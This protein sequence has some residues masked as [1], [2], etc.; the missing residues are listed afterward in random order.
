MPPTSV[1]RHPSL[2]NKKLE[3][4][5][6]QRQKARARLDNKRQK[7]SGHQLFIPPRHDESDETYQSTAPAP[8][9]DNAELFPTSFNMSLAAAE[10]TMH[11]AIR[12]ADLRDWKITLVIVD[13][14]GTPVLVKRLDGAP[15]ASYDIALGRAKNAANF[16]KSTGEIEQ[17][18]QGLDRALKDTE[19]SPFISK[20][21]GC[22]MIVANGRCIGAI[23][24]SG[25]PTA[26]NDE[27]V[28]KQGVTF[29]LSLFGSQNQ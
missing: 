4:E 11:A 13:A 8:D 27:Q 12:F 17:E 26:T 21:G 5:K 10:K 24:V 15:S 19:A 29:I 7:T 6:V 3:E 23:G 20:R 22:P 14:G 2:S 9:I 18:A 16:L 25:A 28:A 1:V